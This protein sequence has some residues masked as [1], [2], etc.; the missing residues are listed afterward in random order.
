MVQR[1]QQIAEALSQHL[2]V[3]ANKVWAYPLRALAQ[4]TMHLCVQK[5][6]RTGIAEA[7]SDAHGYAVPT[8]AEILSSIHVLRATTAAEQLAAVVALPKL[9]KSLSNVRV[10]ILDSMAFHFRHTS[11]DFAAR[12]RS[13]RAISEALRQVAAME[14][15]AVSHSDASSLILLHTVSLAVG[16]NES[17]DKPERPCNWGVCHGARSGR[18]LGTRMHQPNPAHMARIH[19]HCL[20]SQGCWQA[21][22]CL[23]VLCHG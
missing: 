11:G 2:D 23:P 18:V 9:L 15:V 12:S 3:L 19:P 14:T 22:S 20:L 6:R 1:Q 5:R 4:C 17:H 7:S 16:G 8:C 13:I 10:V 21:S